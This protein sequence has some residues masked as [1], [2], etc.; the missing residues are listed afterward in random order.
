MSYDKNDNRTYT[1]DA[2]DN[3]TAVT[4]K[5]EEK[6]FGTYK[7]DQK[8]N[9]IQKTVNGKVTNYFYDGDSLNVLYETDADN[10]PLN[11]TIILLM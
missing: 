7:Y 10:K 1:W 11:S 6:P 4:K 2:E 9:I 8:G 3:L 5:G